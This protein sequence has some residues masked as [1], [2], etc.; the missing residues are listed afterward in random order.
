MSTMRKGKR[1][2]GMGAGWWAVIYRMGGVEGEGE[3]AE[4]C[5]HTRQWP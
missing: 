4:M 3:G 5:V 1:N 2:G